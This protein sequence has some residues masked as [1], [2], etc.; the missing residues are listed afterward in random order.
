[1]SLSTHGAPSESDV[2]PV[3]LQNRTF[4]TLKIRHMKGTATEPGLSDSVN[5][6]LTSNWSFYLEMSSRKTV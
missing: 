1:M 5:E 3:S 4:S 6:F 2:G